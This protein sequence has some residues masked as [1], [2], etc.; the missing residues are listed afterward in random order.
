M[1]SDVEASRTLSDLVNLLEMFR[2]ER[3][4]LLDVGSQNEDL[5]F[6]R[7]MLVFHALYEVL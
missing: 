7:R 6:G 4:G 5:L 3:E 2:K 1:V